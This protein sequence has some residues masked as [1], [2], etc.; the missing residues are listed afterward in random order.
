VTEAERWILTRLKATLADVEQHFA[1]YRFDHLAQALY[2]F[3]WN[4]YCDWFLELAKPALNGGDAEAAASTRHTLLTVLETV[5]RALHPIIPF[6]TEEIWQA[7]PMRSSLSAKNNPASLPDFSKSTIMGCAYPQADEIDADSHAEADVEWLKAVLTGV[8]RIRAEMNIAPG[9]PIALILA[10]GDD[11]DRRRAALFADSLAFLG[12]LASQRWLDASD[13]EPAAAVSVVGK[14]RV[15][16]PLAGLIDLDA[17]KARLE[18][19]IARVEKE[20]KKCEGKLGNSRFVDNAP[21]DVVEQE[22]QR[23]TDWSIQIDAL[24]EQLER[25]G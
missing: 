16:I 18:R 12:R 19:E 1:T 7:L 4:D 14:L 15:L 25:L 8:R 9:K 17:E 23:L 24:R 5:L 10:D 3:V 13:E 21:A 20:I 6:I 2:E 11:E 22:R